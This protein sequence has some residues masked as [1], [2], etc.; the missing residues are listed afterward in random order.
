MAFVPYIPY[1]AA[2]EEVR[3]LHDKY[4]SADGRV[5]NILR[6]HAH[7]PKSWTAHFDLYATLMHGRSEL[8]KVQREMIAVVVSSIN[9][10][11]Y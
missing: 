9:E 5:D 2:S 3:A 10:C 11:H 7:N 1:E 8:S 6:I 4:S